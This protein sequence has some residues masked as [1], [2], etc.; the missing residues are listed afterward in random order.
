MMVAAEVWLHEPRQ[1]AFLAVPSVIRTFVPAGK[2][3]VYMLLRGEIPFYVGRSDRCTQTRLASHPLLAMATHVTW[4]PCTTALHAFHLESAWFHALKSLNQL[5]NQIHPA[6]PVGENKNCPFC[7]TGDCLAWEHA[8]RP[9]REMSA[10]STVASDHTA[11][12]AKT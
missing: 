2:P 1:I 12:A 4:E 10:V 11:A 7:S 5:T 6:R 8:M 3:G 9:R